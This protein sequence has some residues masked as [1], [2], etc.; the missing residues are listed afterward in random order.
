M[1]Q[2]TGNASS[3]LSLTL[4]R[5]EEQAL[6]F[7]ATQ[8]VYAEFLRVHLVAEE[9]ELNSDET[10]VEHVYSID[11]PYASHFARLVREEVDGYLPMMA[12][13]LL[14]KVSR[15]ISAFREPTLPEDVPPL[16]GYTDNPSF[17]YYALS[18][19]G[20]LIAGFDRSDDAGQY[21]K[22]DVRLRVQTRAEVAEH[23]PHLYGVA[24]HASGKVRSEDPDHAFKNFHRA[25]C[26]RF[27]YVHDEVAWKRDLLSLEEWIAKHFSPPAAV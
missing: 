8:Y 1:T 4:T 5:R 25:L 24:S 7:I 3:R 19:D 22:R 15:L 17:S 12:G 26:E 20:Y 9:E 10:G 21:V 18:A 16:V 23:F 27:H 2:E 6:A 13:G 14:M 11:S